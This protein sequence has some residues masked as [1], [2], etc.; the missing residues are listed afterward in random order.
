MRSHK[1]KSVHFEGKFKL[2]ATV[3]NR[4][5]KLRLWSEMNGRRRV[6]I[7]RVREFRV[8]HEEF[9]ACLILESQA[10]IAYAFSLAAC[11][12]LLDF[13]RDQLRSLHQAIAVK[14]TCTLLQTAVNST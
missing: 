6:R 10:W 7:V 5:Y 8:H 4:R 12:N 14:S 1:R 3:T 9:T 2:T 11:Q 13:Y